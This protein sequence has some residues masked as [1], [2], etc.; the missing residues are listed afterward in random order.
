L[1]LPFVWVKSFMA[2]RIR[3]FPIVGHRGAPVFLPPGNT[4]ES[5]RKAV[6]MGAQAVSVN[7]RSTRDEVLVVYH[8]AARRLDGVDT[9]IREHDFARWQSYTADTDLPLIPLVEVLDWAKGAQIGL[10]LDYAEAGTESALARAIRQSGLP[11]DSLLVVGA[12]LPSRQM[13]RSLDP[14]IPLAHTLAPED[15]VSIDA[16]LLAG[17]DTDAVTWHS[18]LLTPPIVKVLH[19]REIVVYGWQVDLRDE[20]LRLRDACAVDGIVTNRPDLLAAL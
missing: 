8:A 7:V 18:R 12:E 20:L 17:L 2:S 16:Q 13:L 11:F 3:S 4:R 1:P 5:L 14:R 10:M 15:H 19:L 9:P 6:E